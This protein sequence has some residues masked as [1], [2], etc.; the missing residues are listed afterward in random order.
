MLG[1]GD[2]GLAIVYA[3]LQEGVKE[4]V[5]TNRSQERAE[6]IADIFKDQNVSVRPWAGRHSL[7]TESDLIVNTT[8]QGMAGQMPLDLSLELAQPTAIVAD[9]IYIPLEASLIKHAKSRALRTVGGLGMLL[10]Q[11]RP[12]WKP[13]FGID[14]EITESL[15]SIMEKISEG[16]PNQPSF[17]TAVKQIRLDRAFG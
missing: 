1:A 15:Y 6:K 8:N 9:I 2:G 5:I 4:I 16:A 7:V 13:W 10:H 11:S 12:A 17:K 14:P 3:L